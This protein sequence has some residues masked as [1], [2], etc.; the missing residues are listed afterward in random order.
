MFPLITKVMESDEMSREWFVTH[1]GQQFGPVTLAD[2]QFEVARKQ[3]NPRLDL[4]WKE[5]MDGWIPA[6]DVGG[7]YEKNEAADTE[8]KKK[9][10]GYSTTIAPQDS[11]IYNSELEVKWGGINRGMYFF[12][13]LV[14]P[15][16]MAF[17][18]GLGANLL[19]EMVAEN[20]LAIAGAGAALVF[21]LVALSA[22]LSRFTNLA[23]SRWW[24]LSLFLPILNFW[25]Y[26]R[27][28]ACPPGYAIHKKL[29]GAGWFLATIYWLLV[30]V[31]I[32]SGI[33]LAYAFS[34]NSVNPES[35]K[36]PEQ[37]LE[38]L[39]KTYTPK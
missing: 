30:L 37:L 15:F 38:I 17:S 32:G 16:I 25:G 12:A 13:T 14:L 26:Y 31:S 39:R 27:L 34:Q 20:H 35:L 3:L 4:V 33:A 24:I 11:R 23:M 22:C 10:E 8:E 28:C 36:T 1:E 21:I 7:L 5:G 2:L 9:A 19:K 6:G 18:V 29:D